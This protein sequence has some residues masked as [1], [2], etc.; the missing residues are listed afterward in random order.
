MK[1]I[2]LVSISLVCTLLC[3]LAGGG[4]EAEAQTVPLLRAA[5]ALLWD[6]VTTDINGGVE[7]VSSYDVAV[8]LPGSDLAARPGDA[9][10]AMAS[11]PGNLVPAGGFPLAGLFQG[12]ASGAYR[13]FLRAID[14][15]GNKSTWSTALDVQVDATAP[16]TPKN[17]R[18]QLSVIVG[19]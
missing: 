2:S 7:S 9:V 6:P 11:S 14:Q 1:A 4:F 5:S 18:I 3:L 10:L 8:T 15:A 13:L 19:P 12:R 17:L 16:A